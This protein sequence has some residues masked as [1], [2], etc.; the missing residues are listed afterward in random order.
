M[1]EGEEALKR[2]LEKEESWSAQVANLQNELR[3]EKERSEVLDK[4]LEANYQEAQS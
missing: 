4:L 1:S 3:K 2:S